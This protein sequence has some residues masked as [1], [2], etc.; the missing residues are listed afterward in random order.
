MKTKNYYYLAAILAVG[1]IIAAIIFRGCD[2]SPSHKV[3]A[4]EVKAAQEQLKKVEEKLA[5][6]SVHHIAVQD[7]LRKVIEDQKA[8]SRAIGNELTKSTSKLQVYVAQLAKARK[9]KDTT[10]YVTNCD[11][12]ARLAALQ[13]EILPMYQRGYDSLTIA[14]EELQASKDSLLKNRQDLI[15]QLRVTNDLTSSK[16]AAIA[17]DYGQVKKKLK[18]ERTLGRILAG[19]AAI[20]GGLLLTK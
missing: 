11:S 9:E 2:N 8:K 1:F 18:R 16:Y 17:A 5:A 10:A 19:G 20:L 3:D 4:K 7:S 14:Y 15:V 13:A 6:D 12:I